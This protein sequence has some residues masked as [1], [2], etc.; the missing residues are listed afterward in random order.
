MSISSVVSPSRLALITVAT[1]GVLAFSKRTAAAQTTSAPGTAWEFRITS[2][3]FVPTGNQRN[4]LKDGQ[5]S[6][7]QLAW[8][9]RPSLAVTGTFGWAR[10]RDLRSADTPKLD[11]FTSDVGVELRPAHWFAGHAVTV[12]PFVGVG[13]GT[14]SYN[15]RKLDVD[16][17]NNLAGYGAVG[18]QVGMRR[19][20]VRLEV[21]DYATGFKPLV[22]PGKSD[23][24]NDVVIMAGLSFNR[25]S[26]SK[27]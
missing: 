9:A 16:A 11:A 22:G 27:D 18:G 2:G 23:T 10:S 14:R 6:A 4:Y 13:A 7:A 8:L 20:A 21:R 26:A 1:L 19:V 24:R 3:A 12:D 15:Y 5:V 17:T 25:H